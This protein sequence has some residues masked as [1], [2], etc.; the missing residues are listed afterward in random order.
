MKP[1]TNRLL[2]VAVAGGPP[3]HARHSQRPARVAASDH[4]DAAGVGEHDLD[5]RLVSVGGLEPVLDGAVS[6]A[7]FATC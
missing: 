3:V 2:E 1:F 5:L 7:S 4:L 6:A